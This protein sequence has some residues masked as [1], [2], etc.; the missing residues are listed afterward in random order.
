[1]ML[2]FASKLLM[3]SDLKLYFTWLNTVWWVD[4]RRNELSIWLEYKT[5][6]IERREMLRRLIKLHLV[7]FIQRS[8]C[9][10]QNEELK[11]R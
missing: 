1:M 8:R 9:T 2:N 5:R 7:N 11:P 10:R 4:S 3:I 6:S